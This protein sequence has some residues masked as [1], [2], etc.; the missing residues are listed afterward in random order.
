MN[1]GVE[2]AGTIETD[3]AAK[4]AGKI[5]T[6]FTGKCFGFWYFARHSGD[7]N[8]STGSAAIMFSYSHHA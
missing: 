1:F 7:I 5:E 6:D 4:A 2:P 8:L 3:L